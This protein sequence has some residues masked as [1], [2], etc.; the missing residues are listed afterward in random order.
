LN[1]TEQL[2]EGVVVLRLRGPFTGE[3]E[4]SEFQKKKYELLEST[5]NK[6]VLDLAGTTMINSAGLGTLISALVSFRDS[7][8]DLRLARLNKTI[9]D[10]IQ[11]VQLDK[12]FKIYDTVEKAVSSFGHAK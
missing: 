10:V 3:P 8:G 7:G 6:I 4:S 9:D 1:I 12:V 5:K 2:R 11:K